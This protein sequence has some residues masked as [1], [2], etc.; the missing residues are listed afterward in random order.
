MGT[1]PLARCPL[2]RELA[3]LSFSFDQSGV[4]LLFCQASHRCDLW[5]P[6][7]RVEEPDLRPAEKREKNGTTAHLHAHL[8]S[9]SSSR[10]RPPRPFYNC[11]CRHFAR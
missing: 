4:S 3:H 1:S 6:V 11:H 8:P 2:A 10:L 5:L 7:F 9:F